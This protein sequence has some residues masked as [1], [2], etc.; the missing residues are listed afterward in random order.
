MNILQGLTSK[1]TFCVTL[2]HLEGIDPNR[3]IRKIT[4]HH[5][6]YT[7][8]T[9]KAQ[10]RHAEISG[11]RRTHFAGAYWGFGFHEDGVKSG[12]RVAN[13]ILDSLK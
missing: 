10:A 1:E 4:Y 11:V 13:T 7:P 5:P 3:I 9:L 2:N 8:E 6:A 12:L